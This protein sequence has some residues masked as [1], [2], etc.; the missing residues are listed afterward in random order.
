MLGTLSE[1]QE[2]AGIFWN[3]PLRIICTQVVMICHRCY[4]TTHLR[5]IVYLDFICLAFDILELDQTD[6]LDASR[7]H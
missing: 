7:F 1:F 6:L 5:I 2:K 3:H 4:H